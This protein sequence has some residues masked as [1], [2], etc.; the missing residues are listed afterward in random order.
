MLSSPPD[1]NHMNEHLLHIRTYL[2]AGTQGCALSVLIRAYRLTRQKHFLQVAWRV[3]QT[4]QRD[5]LDGGVALPVQNVGLFFE[6]CGCYPA[7][8]DLNSFLLAMLGLIEYSTLTGVHESTT[9]L[10]SAHQTLHLLLSEF[11][12]GYWTR[13]DL[14]QRRLSTLT[15]IV[16]QITILDV[17]ASYTTCELCV[18]TT[19]RWL[20]YTHNKYTLLRYYLV[21]TAGDIQQSLSLD[22]KQL[23]NLV[24]AGARGAT[25]R[26]SLLP[27]QR[28]TPWHESIEDTL[29]RSAVTSEEKMAL[30]AERGLPSDAILLT[31]G[32][33]S[34]WQ[35]VAILLETLDYVLSAVP[36][37]LR[38][39]LYWLITED[40]KW[41]ARL[42]E[43]VF[44]RGLN[45]NCLFL[46]GLPCQAALQLHQVGDIYI[47][48]EH[49]YSQSRK[50]AIQAMAAGSVL[51]ALKASYI[52]LELL[53]CGT[54]QRLPLYSTEYIGD[55]LLYLLSYEERRLEMGKRAMDVVSG[56]TITTL[57]QRLLLRAGNQADAKYFMQYPLAGQ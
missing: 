20:R 42:E 29:D 13:R 38:L 1:H 9:L 46:S 11:D 6:E 27:P 2:S 54:G 39:R 36:P 56:S 40:E 3:L 35:E 26:L 51:I 19:Q 14:L 34:S 12:T 50:N 52:G 28:V 33:C 7:S 45:L 8:Y 41:H 22:S 49:N 5:I 24:T 23:V 48:P 4:F 55:A 15:D 32:H 17:V 57:Q 18:A 44:Q 37:E 47:V 31:N 43:E 25:T 53:A 10:H 30:R 16:Q 21:K